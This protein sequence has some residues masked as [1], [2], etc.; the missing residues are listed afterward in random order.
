VATVAGFKALF[1]QFSAQADA[2]IE[3]WFDQ[4]P[5]RFTASRFG[6]QWTMAV[7]CY[8]AHNLVLFNPD[9]IDMSEQGVAT[10][11]VTARKVGDLSRSYG[12]SIDMARVPASMM[13]FTSTPYGQRL[14]GI[15]LSRSAGHARVVLTGSS[16]SGRLY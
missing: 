10:G 15:F 9:A 14:I 4:A 13:E 3:A 5:T 7:Y 2:E 6:L 16:L 8:T 12:A 11:P 1:P